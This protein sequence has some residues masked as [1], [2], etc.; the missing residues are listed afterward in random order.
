MQRRHPKEQS[1][2]GVFGMETST[3]LMSG[4]G[5]PCK[6]MGEMSLHLEH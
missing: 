5:M 2:L 4:E 1:S 6:K 3:T